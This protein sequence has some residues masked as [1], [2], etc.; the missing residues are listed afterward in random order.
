MTASTPRA[1]KA[2][3]IIIGDW[4][5]RTEENGFQGAGQDSPD[6]LRAFSY[7]PEV[8]AKLTTRLQ[9]IRRAVAD[10]PVELPGISVHAVTE[11]KIDPRTGA[12]VQKTDAYLR[13]AT[14]SA[15]AAQSEF[16]MQEQ[17]YRHYRHVAKERGLRISVRPTNVEAPKWRAQGALPKP[18]DI[19]AK[20]ISPIDVYL[21]ADPKNIGLV[22]YFRPVMPGQEDVPDANAHLWEEIKARHKQRSQE[23]E[24]L[25]P[26]MEKLAAEGK[27]FVEEGLVHGLD[28]DGVRR[29]IT[30]DEDL[31]N[32][33]TPA[34]SPLS[35]GT[36]DALMDHMIESNT[37]TMH[38]AHMYW[39]PPRS[40]F[41]EQIYDKI[42]KSHQ[43][44]GE[45]L[46]EFGPDYE[47]PVL[48]WAQPPSRDSTTE[49]DVVSQPGTRRTRSAVDQGMSNLIKFAE[50]QRSACSQAQAQAQI[51]DAARIRP[52]GRVSTREHAPQPPA[53]PH[54]ANQ[55]KQRPSR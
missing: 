15:T 53:Q 42:V 11:Q 21:G 45:P 30:G 36:Y 32:L 5:S 38:G 43:V 37:A 25:A 48:V 46:V 44:G 40:P 3:K 6:D 16:G 33:L 49:S 31:F 10:S 13:G 50:S 28:G 51:A 19:K 34:G 29:P 17:S 35:P 22:G 47:N 39:P 8:W 9:E 27:F 7:D 1:R 41:S 2:V 26:V 14:V 24:T 52:H 55:Q 20:T 12:T 54:K 4:V 18:K 23:F